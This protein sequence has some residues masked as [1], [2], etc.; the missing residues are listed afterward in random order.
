[1]NAVG[2]DILLYVHDP[3]D[4]AKQT[5]SATIVQSLTGRG[6]SLASHL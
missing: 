6:A 1:M 5:T 3:R 4:P 2:T